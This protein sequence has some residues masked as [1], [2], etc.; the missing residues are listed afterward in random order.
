M[1]RFRWRGIQRALI[2]HRVADARA[3]GAKVIFSAVKYGD[4]SW[5]NMRRVGLRE[6]FLTLS[7]RR[8]A[9]TR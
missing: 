5:A 2:A 3:A 7:Y 4:G 6:A 8:P 9:A 1:P